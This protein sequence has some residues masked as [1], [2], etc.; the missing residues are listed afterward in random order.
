MDPR[1]DLYVADSANNV[2]RVIDPNG[3]IR[4]FAGNGH[5]GLSG[6][7]GLAIHATLLAPSGLAYAGGMLY[8]AD[9]QNDLVRRV[10]PSGIITTIAGTN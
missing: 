2:I 1:G 8:I 7:G 3:T 5:P 9:Q 4:T 6:N 10:D